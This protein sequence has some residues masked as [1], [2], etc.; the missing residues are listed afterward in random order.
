MEPS[1]VVTKSLDALGRCPSMVPGLTNRL[2]AWILS[3]VVPRR[4]AIRIMGN[5]TKKMYGIRP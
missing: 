3:A 2:A 4:A 5:T 1:R